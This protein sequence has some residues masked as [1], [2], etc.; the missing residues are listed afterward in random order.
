MQM[1]QAMGEAEN[2]AADWLTPKKGSQIT[3]CG[4]S[5]VMVNSDGNTSRGPLIVES[6]KVH[7]LQSH[8]DRDQNLHVYS[9]SSCVTSGKL[10]N[11]SEPYFPYL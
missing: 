6:E 5:S 11:L 4:S 9:L 8:E 3:C 10:F 1:P 2:P 7:G